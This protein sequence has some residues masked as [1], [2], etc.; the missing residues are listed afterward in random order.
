MTDTRPVWPHKEMSEQEFRAIAKIGMVV[1]VTAKWE[2][3]SADTSREWLEVKTHAGKTFTLPQGWESVLTFVG[4][5]SSPGLFEM[6]Y[7]GQRMQ[8]TLGEINKWERQNK[9]ERAQYE[10]LKAKFEG[11]NQ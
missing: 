6:N 8:K 3:T 10:R 9:N 11:Q 1:S 2:F 5:S 7:T 4:Y